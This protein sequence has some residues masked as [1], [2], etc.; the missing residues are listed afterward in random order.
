[1]IFTLKDSV[2]PIIFSVKLLFYL[3]IV[4]CCLIFNEIIIIKA[5]GLDQ[6]IKQVI[7]IRGDDEYT[8]CKEDIEKLTI[9]DSQESEPEKKEP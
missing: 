5:W 7:T 4:I 6:G 8:H 1:M 3:I 2:D 9:I